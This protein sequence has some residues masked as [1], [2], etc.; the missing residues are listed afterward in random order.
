MS[1]L[2]R[3]RVVAAVVLGGC[4]GAMGAGTY[5]FLEAA[6]APKS[7]IAELRLHQSA[8]SV[9]RGRWAAW[10]DPWGHAF[11]LSFFSRNSDRS[12][13]GNLLLEVRSVGRDGVRATEDD[14]FVRFRLQSDV[15]GDRFLPIDSQNIEIVSPET[16]TIS[17]TPHS[18]GMR[19]R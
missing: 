15:D 3:G 5:L 17:L 19:E 11:E 6:S 14:L 2:G 8:Q 16:W 12:D 7:A 9:S 10:T 18:E 4:L 13:S 1:T